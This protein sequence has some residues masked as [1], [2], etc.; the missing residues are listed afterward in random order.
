MSASHSSALPQRTTPPS[1]TGPA[2][3]QAA[4]TQVMAVLPRVMDA[5]RRAM[6]AQ[7]DG[8]LTVPQFRGLNFIDHQPGSSVSDLA[9]F[10]GVSLATASAMVDRLARAGHVQTQGSRDDRRRLELRLCA[11]GK[12]VL[13]R[14]HQQTRDDLA[15][16][17]E[18]RSAAELQAL[19]EG[20]RV[21]ESAFASVKE[22]AAG[23]AGGR[24]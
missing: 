17:L 15:E 4:A 5:M 24:E 22:P 11:S 1:P 6:R 16:A 23:R 21:L 20:L 7:L 8:P 9:G 13:E 3:A 14:M 2:S 19:V 12:A 18:G 10:L